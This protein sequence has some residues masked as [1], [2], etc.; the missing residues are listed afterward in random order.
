[1]RDYDSLAKHVCRARSAAAD[2]PTKEPR[3][4]EFDLRA[5]SSAISS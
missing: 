1:M 3:T 5:S 4:G 2:A